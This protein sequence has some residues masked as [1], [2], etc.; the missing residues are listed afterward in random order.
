MVGIL[1]GTLSPT[2]FGLGHRT[3]TS[4]ALDSANLTSTIIAPIG[5][6]KFSIK[7]FLYVSIYVNI[8]GI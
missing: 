4:D 5:F 3:L 6:W 2:N 8:Q 7:E 1:T